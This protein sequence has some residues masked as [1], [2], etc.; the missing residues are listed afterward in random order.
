MTDQHSGEYIAGIDEVGRGPLAGP[1]MAAAVLLFAPMAGLAD[2]KTL[3]PARREKLASALIASDQVKIGLGAASVDEID[4]LNILQATLLAMQRAFDRLGFTPDLVL[5][6]GNR[7][8]TLPCPA[9]AV[10]GGDRLVPAI[11]AASIVAKV[12]RDR[13]MA[14]LDDRYPGYGWTK[15]VGYPT[16][17]HRNAL[18]K[19]GP[20]RHHRQSFAPVKAALEISRAR[21]SLSDPARPEP[22]AD[23]VHS[24]S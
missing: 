11:A 16:V 8:P 19:L 6:D 5:V 24:R 9:K 1:V 14:R 13:L 4:R 23:S 12:T 22:G 21:P 2:S 7:L 15:N 20:S 17:E 3:S 10:V 18:I